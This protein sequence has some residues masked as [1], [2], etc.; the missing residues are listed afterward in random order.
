MCVRCGK[1]SMHEKTQGICRGHKWVVEGE[2]EVKQL[3]WAN[4]LMGEHA[5]QKKFDKGGRFCDLCARFASQCLRDRLPN[6]CGPN[7]LYRARRK[8]R[9]N[10]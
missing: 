2:S 6:V 8:A 7:E 4:K 10:T 3:R 1:R 5:L 9:S